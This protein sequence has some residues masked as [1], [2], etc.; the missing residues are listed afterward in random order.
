MT[1]LVLLREGLSQIVN[2]MIMS[3]DAYEK[4][5][6]DMGKKLE[7]PAPEAKDALSTHDLLQIHETYKSKIKE[8][9]ENLKNQYNLGNKLVDD[10]N[11][12]FEKENL[13]QV[14]QLLGNFQIQVQL[15]FSKQRTLNDEIATLEGKIV[16]LMKVNTHL[17]QI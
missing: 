7:E 15:L 11:V 17:E 5:I 16:S 8:A 9:L 14:Q 12:S 10:L 3:K 2:Q 13:Q 4:L 1:T 6:L